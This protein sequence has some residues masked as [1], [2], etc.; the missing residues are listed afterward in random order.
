MDCQKILSNCFCVVSKVVRL[1]HVPSQHRRV[2]CR[3]HQK[4]GISQPVSWLLWQIP[5][6]V[7]LGYQNLELLGSLQTRISPKVTLV[8]MEIRYDPPAVKLRDKKYTLLRLDPTPELGKTKQNSYIH[9]MVVNIRGTDITSG[10]EVYDWLLPMTSTLNQLYLFAL[11]EQTTHVGAATART[12][13]GANCPAFIKFSMRTLVL[14]CVLMAALSVTHGKGKAGG[15]SLSK[16]RQY[17][18]K[19]WIVRIF[20]KKLLHFLRMIKGWISISRTQVKLLLYMNRRH[21]VRNCKLYR[22][23]ATDRLLHNDLRLTA[24]NY[25]KMGQIIG[26]RIKMG[27]RYYRLL[28]QSPPPKFTKQMEKT[29]AMPGYLSC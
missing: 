1:Q 23:Y 18:L 24:K 17:A 12:Y 10:D 27:W 13:G 7:T 29:L 28:S 4:A 21:M 22:K 11:F 15:K 3:L 5:V 26:L 9:C 19:T 20:D 16:K 6:N 8:P 25:A 2:R 14:V